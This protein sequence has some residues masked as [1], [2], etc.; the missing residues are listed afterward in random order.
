MH[1][2][3]V[4]DNHLNSLKYH[5]RPSKKIKNFED[6]FKHAM[7]YILK[8]R[9]IKMDRYN[10]LTEF[11]Y[12]RINTQANRAIEEYIKSPSSNH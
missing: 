6:K 7:K 9:K 8:D 11:I 4:I 12:F 1:Y 3:N 10:L 5:T 2:T